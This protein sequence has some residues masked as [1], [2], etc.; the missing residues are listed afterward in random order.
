MKKSDAEHKDNTRVALLSGK[1]ERTLSKLLADAGK[2]LCKAKMTV[3]SR[4]ALH[5]ETNGS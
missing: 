3:H 5:V 1:N 4:M 2:T